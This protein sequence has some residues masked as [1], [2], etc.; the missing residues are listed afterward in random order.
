[1]TNGF[2]ILPKRDLSI[3]SVLWRLSA[4]TNHPDKSSKR[5]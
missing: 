4:S 1:M 5:E 2:K 3:W